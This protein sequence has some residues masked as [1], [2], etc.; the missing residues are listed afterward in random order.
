M[1]A[2]TPQPSTPSSWVPATSLPWVA[3]PRSLKRPGTY[4]SEGYP[5]NARTFRLG[6][7]HNPASWDH[8]PTGRLSLAPQS[9]SPPWESSLLEVSKPLVR[10]ATSGCLS[11]WR[12][13]AGQC[14]LW[15]TSSAAPCCRS[16]GLSLSLTCF[17]FVKPSQAPHPS[18]AQACQEGGR[19]SLAA[20]DLGS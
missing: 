17:N 2:L 3:D 1:V 20:P 4:F 13:R 9:S 8:G 10:L 14:D 19:G 12:Q 16:P 7:P 15:A 5:Q 6:H 18:P 11:A